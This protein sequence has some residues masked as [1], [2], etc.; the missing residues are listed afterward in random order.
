MVRLAPLILII[1]G[2]FHGLS[3]TVD[4]GFAI[5][6]EYP[7]FCLLVGDAFTNVVIMIPCFLMENDLF[8]VAD[9]FSIFGTDKAVTLVF[10]L[11]SVEK[12]TDAE[13]TGLFGH[14]YINLLKHFSV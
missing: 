10:D 6:L 13:E 9:L 3:F 11:S 4:H 8:T 14:F 7:I 1:T 5:F 12:T 2:L